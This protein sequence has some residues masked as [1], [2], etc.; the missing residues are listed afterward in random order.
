MPEMTMR[1]RMLA[2]VHGRENDRVP[3]AQYAGPA[4]V[5][6]AWELVG[7][8]NLGLMIWT[9]VHRHDTPNCRFEHEEVE[10]DGRRG[11]RTTLHTPEGTL[12][13]ERLYQPDLGVLA[14]KEHFVKEPEDYGVLLAYLRDIETHVDLS[15]YRE[16]EERLGD[17]GIPHTAV[18]RTPFQQLWI[19]WVCL[20]DLCLHLADAPELVEEVFAVM[21]EVQHRTFE[22][23]VEAARRVRLSH[24]VFPDNITAPVI[25]PKYFRR[26]CVSA[27]N[28]LADMLADAGGDVKLFSHTDGDLK[29]LW[30]AIGESKLAG[31]DSLSPPPD[32]DTSVAAAAEMWP[33]MRL[34]V[35]FPSSVHLARPEV[36]YR[37]ARDILDQ[38]GHTGRLQI[39]ISENVPPGRWKVS[40][41]QIVRAIEDFGR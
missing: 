25:G 34:W 28:E 4:P 19:Q 41:P 20:E 33:R 1:S 31:L 6:E 9:G 10:I 7:R 39:Q 26:L 36:I 15:R 40:Y 13:E 38:A 11:R 5:E 16:A 23:V 21:G 2:V 37:T 27:Y 32:N 3:F 14:A 8:E 18:D 12:R 17:D 24:V 22:A 30:A 35:N 29:P